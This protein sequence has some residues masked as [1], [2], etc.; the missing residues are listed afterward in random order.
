MESASGFQSARARP[1]IRRNRDAQRAAREHAAMMTFLGP[2]AQTVS[3]AGNTIS[4][5]AHFCFLGVRVSFLCIR[6]AELARKG[7]EHLQAPYLH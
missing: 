2:L 4:S 1:L 6:R 7:K 5:Y 3:L